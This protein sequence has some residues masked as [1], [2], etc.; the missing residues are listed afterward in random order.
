MRGY[1]KG[2]D[3]DQLVIDYNTA[4]E[5]ENVLINDEKVDNK[6]VKFEVN[7]YKEDSVLGINCWAGEHLN[8]ISEEVLD[9][10]KVIML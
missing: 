6:V 8:F 7:D 5:F 1:N 10:K 2:I 9:V 4:E 3:N